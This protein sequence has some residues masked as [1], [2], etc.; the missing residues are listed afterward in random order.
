MTEDKFTIIKLNNAIKKLNEVIDKNGKPFDD[1]KEKG[2]LYLKA[3]V[4]NLKNKKEN[5]IE[6]IKSFFNLKQNFFNIYGEEFLEKLWELYDEDELNLNN[7]DLNNNNNNNKINYQKFFLNLFFLNSTFFNS[8]TL[9]NFCIFNNET[10]K[11]TF[12]IENI[13]SLSLTINTSI[14][15]LTLYI[16]SHSKINTFYTQ[17]SGFL[18]SFNNSVLKFYKIVALFSLMFFHLKNIE[19]FV[20]G[21]LYIFGGILRDLGRCYLKTKGIYNENLSYNKCGNENKNHENHIS[22]AKILREKEV[23]LLKFT[24]LEVICRFFE[25]IENLVENLKENNSNKYWDD[26]KIN[27]QKIQEKK[28]NLKICKNEE[29]KKVIENEK[30]DIISNIDNLTKL[31]YIIMLFLSDFLFFFITNFTENNF[32]LNIKS[33]FSYF[34]EFLNLSIN[35]YLKNI[36]DI[37]NL[38]EFSFNN[39]RFLEIDCEKTEYL[40]EDKFNIYGIIILFLMLLK[41]NKLPLIF[42]KNIYVENYNDLLFLLVQRENKIDTKLIKSYEDVCYEIGNLMKNKN[43][44]DNKR[45]NL[46]KEFQLAKI[47]DEKI[48]LLFN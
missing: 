11:L 38:W 18:L 34:S 41:L 12:N 22:P 23:D 39:Q 4:N 2:T 40:L 8:L 3:Y 9:N 15:I 44:F 42:N 28:E 25:N 20:A 29:E 16:Y 27:F 17:T 7:F 26:C 31:N 5:I 36:R 33:E 32:I 48:N 46:K 47:N 24:L 30:N 10:N 21:L 45:E 1:I 37:F 35:F 14:D 19:N 13:N 43:I 6:S